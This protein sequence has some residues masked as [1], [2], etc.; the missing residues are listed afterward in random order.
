MT[1]KQLIFHAEALAKLIAGVSILADAVR[2][3]LGPKARTVVLE[4]PF[5]APIVINSGVVVAKE[6]ELEDRFENMGAQMVKE[7]AVKTSDV[8]GDGTTTATLF[9]YLSPYFINVAEKQR[10]ALEDAYV[11][12]IAELPDETRRSAAAAAE[13]AGM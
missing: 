8:A 7:V 3:T 10:V 13:M 4:R 12:M 9:A 5:G 6:I 1:S 2:P 11:L